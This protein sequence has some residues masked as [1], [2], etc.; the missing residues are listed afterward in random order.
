MCSV[1]GVLVRFILVSGVCWVRYFSISVLL[2][3][4]Y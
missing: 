4:I 2:V 1:S 3:G